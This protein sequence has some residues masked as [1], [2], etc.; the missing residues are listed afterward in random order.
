MTK[1]ICLSALLCS[2]LWGF[3]ACGDDDDDDDAVSGDYEKTATLDVKKYVDGEL[4][5]LYDAS[6]ALQ[7]AAPDPDADGWNAKDDKPAVDA[8]KA[9]WADARDAYERVEGSIALLFRDLDKSTDERYDGF[10]NDDGPD[11][12]LFDGEGVTGVHA[13]ERILWADS[14]PE[15]VLE[16][17][18]TV[19]GY[20]TAAFP[21]NDEEAWAFKHELVGRLVTD[22]KSMKDDYATYALDPSAAFWGIIGSMAE[23]S[24]KTT[25]GASGEDE[26]RYAQR[27]LADMR[28]NLQGANAVFKAFR[29]WVVSSNGAATATEIQ[30]G[31]DNIGDAYAEVKSD[32]LPEVPDGFNPDSPTDEEL[33]SPYGKLWALLNAETD[34]N[35]KDSLINKMAAAADGMGIPE[36]E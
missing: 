21:S 33:E 18:K 34:A 29:A 17:E 10:L 23:Q 6:L 27:T 7:K 28:A 30:A 5:N 13:I 20:T 22:T 4:Q 12:N 15:R 31:L 16:F 1:Q 19:P 8:M 36:F 24:E 32:A 26:S 3:A 14:H 9:A 35:S 11:D 2:S 25:L